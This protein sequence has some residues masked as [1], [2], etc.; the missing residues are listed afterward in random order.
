MVTVKYFLKF[1]IFIKMIGEGVVR[2]K[3]KVC[4]GVALV[5]TGQEAG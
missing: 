4:L 3:F 1:I 2:D 5:L